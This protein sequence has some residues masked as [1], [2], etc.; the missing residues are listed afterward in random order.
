MD[1]LFLVRDI[2]LFSGW[3]VDLLKTTVCIF[4]MKSKKRKQF[5]IQTWWLLV[6]PGNKETIKDIG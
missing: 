3:I 1:R 6:L 2:L 5:S 4:P